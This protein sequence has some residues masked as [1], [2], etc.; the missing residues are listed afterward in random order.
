VLLAEVAGILRG[1][2]EGE[3]DEAKAK[4]KAAAGVCRGWR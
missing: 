1:T 2:H 3:L 4:A